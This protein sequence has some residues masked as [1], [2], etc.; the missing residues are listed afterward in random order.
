MVLLFLNHSIDVVHA[1]K[2]VAYVLFGMIWASIV[3]G[4]GVGV[5]GYRGRRIG[6]TVITSVSSA[7]MIVT[8][9]LTF[10]FRGFGGPSLSSSLF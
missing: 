2:F 7:V 3:P 1:C 10:L 5:I 8:L 6:S 4:G 9:N